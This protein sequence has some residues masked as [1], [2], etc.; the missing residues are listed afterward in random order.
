M[1]AKAKA[2]A[3]AAKA[4]AGA[5]AA[6]LDAKHGIR[7]KAAAAKASAQAKAAEL[8]AKHGISDKAASVKASA[9]RSAREKQWGKVA[10]LFHEFDKDQSDFLD[11]EEVAEL[12]KA[13]GLQLSEVEV[14]QALDEMEADETRD[15]KVQFEEFLTWWQSDSQAKA[16]GSL[17]L[18][19]QQAKEAA[20]SAELAAGTPM[21]KLMSAKASAGAA[22]KGAAASAGQKIKNGYARAKSVTPEDKQRLLGKASTAMTV[23]SV[24][25][26][27]ARGTKYLGRGLMAANLAR[28]QGSEGGDTAAGAAGA[29]GVAG[30]GSGAERTEPMKL[31]LTA[32]VAAGQTMVFTVDGYPGEYAV[33]VPAG[34]SAGQQFEFEGDLVG[35][36]GPPAE[37]GVPPAGAPVG[38]AAA[39]AAAARKQEAPKSM[40]DKGLDGVQGLLGNTKAGK[41]L[42]Q[43]RQ[44]EALAAKA[45]IKVTPKQAIEAAKMANKV[46]KKL[47]K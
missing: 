38:A 22:V 33:E 18:R 11:C 3:E 37:E 31:T 30:A 13:L 27:A 9:T 17:A 44:A 45:G 1:L 20:Y 43:A 40:K 10:Q 2:K 12:C 39:A 21:D 36:G 46:Q 6:D 4:A 23:A 16:A 28:S 29:A 14:P 32:T 47:P 24:I 8:D 35:R 26:P 41:Q 19:L 15:G 25:C 7:D 42:K 5:K 34:V